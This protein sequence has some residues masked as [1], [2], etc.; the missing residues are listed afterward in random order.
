MRI[1]I[2]GIIIALIVVG[3][4]VSYVFANY[5]SNSINTSIGISDNFYYYFALP[6]NYLIILFVTKRNFF[7]KYIDMIIIC[8]IPSLILLYKYFINDVF[9]F[10]AFRDIILSGLISCVLIYYFYLKITENYKPILEI[11]STSNLKAFKS[12]SKNK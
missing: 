4:T 1:K 10:L 6:I 7:G 9:D 12:D 5:T 8:L 2:L 3:Y 11:N